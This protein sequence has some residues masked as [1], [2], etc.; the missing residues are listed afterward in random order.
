VSEWVSETAVCGRVCENGRHAQGARWT[1][2]CGRQLAAVM[3]GRHFTSD[4]SGHSGHWS[5]DGDDGCA[6]TA[7]ACFAGR[8]DYVPTPP[9][10]LPIRDVVL[11]RSATTG[12]GVPEALVVAVV[13]RAGMG[14]CWA[15]GHV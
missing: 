3:G 5:A 4:T 14:G 7:G 2:A 10:Y 8:D 15:G 11:Q 6:D 12:G 9:T 1:R 13:G